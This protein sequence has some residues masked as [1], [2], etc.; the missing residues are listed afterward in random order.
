M[1]TGIVLAPVPNDEGITRDTFRRSTDRH[2]VDPF[3][4]DVGCAVSGRGQR[5]D[6]EQPARRRQVWANRIIVLAFLAVAGAYVLTALL[7]GRA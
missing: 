7:A 1:R 3:R 2:P 4:G 6:E 5:N